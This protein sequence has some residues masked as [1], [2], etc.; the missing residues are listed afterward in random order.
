[1]KRKVLILISSLTLVLFAAALVVIAVVGHNLGLFEGRYQQMR[2]YAALLRVIDNRFIGDFDLDDIN[3]T[4]MT[5][6]VASLDDDWSFFLTAEA[7]EN[8]LQNARNIYP[9]IGIQVRSE[10]DLDGILI[11][12]VHRDSPAYNAGL[13]PGD[14]ITHV[15]GIDISLKFLDEVIKLIRRP[16]GESVDLTVLREDGTIT[17][18]NPVADFV[19]INPVE[20]D[21]IYTDIGLIT[22]LNFGAGAADEFISAVNSL[23]DQNAGAFIFDVRGNRGG[24]VFEMTRILDKLLPEGEIF[25]TVD[26]TGDEQIFLSDSEK[27]DLPMAVL[28]DRHSYSAAEFFA[29]IMREYDHAV[30][31]GE[32][33]TGK[34]RMQTLHFLPG[35]NAINLSTAEYLTKNR[36]SLHDAGGV[37]P[38]YLIEF[39]DDLRRLFLMGNLELSEDIHVV[40][41]L[42]LLKSELLEVPGT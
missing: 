16:V 19:F 40:K 22:I 4:A 18:K 41:A 6:A 31:I 29:A 15:D 34:S 35:G 3:I 27:I 28:V 7:L 37:T 5:A 9:G 38:D 21:L 32:Q 23:L 17:V 8:M 13:L 20:Y 25:V 11:I 26:R 12:H 24:S 42:E 30:I 36:I 1:M 39:S 10:E 14:I 2:Q 33:T